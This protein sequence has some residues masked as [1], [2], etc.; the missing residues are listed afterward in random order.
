MFRP[1]GGE[2]VVSSSCT[3]T[4]KLEGRRANVRASN[5]REPELG[6][7]VGV[8]GSRSQRRN[9]DR[10]VGSTGALGCDSGRVVQTRNGGG[11]PG[12]DVDETRVKGQV[13]EG[14]RRGRSLKEDGNRVRF[15]VRTPKRER[16]TGESTGKRPRRDGGGRETG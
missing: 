13:E 7:T 5:E 6:P 8:I 11:T 3:P 12:P 9:G 14:G 2:S 16:E 4:E 15:D 10:H 1:S